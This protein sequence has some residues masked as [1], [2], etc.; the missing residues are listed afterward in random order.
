[1]KKGKSS[2]FMPKDKLGKKSSIEQPKLSPE[3]E[4]QKKLTEKIVKY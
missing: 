4:R 3:M 2:G 1:M